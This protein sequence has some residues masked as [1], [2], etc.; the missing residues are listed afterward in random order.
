MPG[1]RVPHPRPKTL[2]LISSCTLAQELTSV[3]ITPL[4]IASLSTAALVSLERRTS[5]R[6]TCCPLPRFR[7]GHSNNE[8]VP[9]PP[10]LAAPPVREGR[11]P[12]PTNEGG[13][14][15]AVC[16]SSAAPGLLVLQ[17]CLSIGAT[18]LHSSETRNNLK[19][20]HSPRTTS[21]Q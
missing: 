8:D 12:A 17:S 21:A 2:R 1:E 13:K 19:I 4:G 18:R 7:A 14:G 9:A 5:A 20:S 15:E 11:L 3:H 10:L 16:P 6:K